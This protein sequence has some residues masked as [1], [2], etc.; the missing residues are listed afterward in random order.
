MSELQKIEQAY[1]MGQLEDENDSGNM[2]NC[3]RKCTLSTEQVENCS[4]IVL[5]T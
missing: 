2:W 1:L 4:M 3:G 5:L